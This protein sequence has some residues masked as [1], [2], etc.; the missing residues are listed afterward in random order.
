MAERR[1]IARHRAAVGWGENAIVVA[2]GGFEIT[3]AGDELELD[4]HETLALIGGRWRAMQS[5][6]RPRCDCGVAVWRGIMACV[7]GSVTAWDEEWG[8][9]R[10]RGG[11]PECVTFD[12][13]ENRWLNLGDQGLI[14]PN[15][16]TA[17]VD[18][19]SGALVVVAGEC[20]SWSDGPSSSIIIHG[21][22]SSMLALD[23]PSAA[24]RELTPPPQPVCSAFAA[25]IGVK[26]YVAGGSRDV[27]LTAALQGGP[28]GVSD[29]L[30]IYDF[31]TKT[32]SFGPPLPEIQYDNGASGCAHGNKLYVVSGKH[33]IGEHTSDVFI[34]DVTTETWSEGPP[35]PSPRMMHTTLVHQNRIIVIGGE[36]VPLVLDKA[37][38]VWVHDASFVPYL[39]GMASEEPLYAAMIAS[40]PV[41]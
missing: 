29:K 39:P 24:W 10:I 41:G 11:V 34:Y 5:Q 19:V 26:L 18:P 7:G 38:G 14:L 13:V 20:E 25:V 28:I 36:G 35:L 2:G 15:K 3:E 21:N 17:V 1:A 37:A 4:R 40:V 23:S 27:G 30:Q 6:F 9:N 8:E 33:S 32:W 31:Q 12:G 16:G 22:M